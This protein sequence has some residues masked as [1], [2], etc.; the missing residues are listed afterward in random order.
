LKTDYAKLFL[1]DPINFKKVSQ[2]NTSY[3]SERL[4]EII[5]SVWTAE[6]NNH[7]T[8][9]EIKKKCIIP[10]TD[11]DLEY[12]EKENM[13]KQKDNHIT[14]TKRGRK[15]AETI[16]RRHRIA[17]VLVSSILKLKT[18]DM[19]RVACE[20]EHSLMP[21]VEEAIC[22]LLGHPEFCPDGNPIPQGK[23]C[24]KRIN[25]IHKTVI[26]LSQLRDGESG[27][28]AYIK[29]ESHATLEHL[30]SLGFSPGII[31]TVEQTRPVF[32]LKYENTELAIDRDIVNTIF[33]W[34]IE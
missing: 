31:I 6:E 26:S 7:F 9:E 30:M 33:V 27:K 12:L 4:E 16:V 15:L 32:C 5:E 10:F 18:S 34:K 13:I 22:T 2:M 25:V 17:E 8:K 1:Y 20:L 3:L 19:E 14:F 29:P 21:E 24:K 28:I 11:D 23:C